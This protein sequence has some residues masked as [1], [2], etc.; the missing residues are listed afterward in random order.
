LT[1]DE[2][3]TVL[4]DVELSRGTIDSIR[5]RLAAEG[6]EL[7][8]SI[9]DIDEMLPTGTDPNGPVAGAKPTPHVAAV[10]APRAPREAPERSPERGEGGSLGGRTDNA[11]TG[12]S[13]DPVRTYLKE[14]GKVSLLTGPE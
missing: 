6:I 5:R 12:G 9:E 2:V 3:M 1:V 11:R 7:D 10:K 13:S 14:I 8:E 4:R